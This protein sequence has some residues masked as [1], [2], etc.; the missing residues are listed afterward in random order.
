MWEAEE[1]GRLISGMRGAFAD[2]ADELEVTAECNPASFD[3]SVGEAFALAGINRISLGVQSLDNERLRFLGRLHDSEQ[4]LRAI[5]DAQ[6]TH[7]RVSCDLMFGMPGQS[8]DD[9]HEEI[10]RVV[11][12]GIRHVSAY[13]LTIEPETPFGALHREGKLQVAPEEEYADLFEGATRRFESLGFEHYEV[14]N[15]AAPGEESVHNLHYWRGGDYLGLG[16]GA[17]GCV[18]SAQGKARRWRN[19][20]DSA[21]YMNAAGSEAQELESESLDAQDLIREALMLGLRTLEGVDLKAAETRAGVDPLE[22]RAEAVERHLERGNLL[23][24]V[25]EEGARLRVPRARWL[26]LDGIVA[27]LF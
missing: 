1:L 5:D 23:L 22:G 7:E 14:S 20:P 3:R 26:H 12:R 16:A 17:V 11:A 18:T 21:R 15:Y 24:D 13:A 2:A 9:L 27:D 25:C 19:D 4:A 8:V 6:R 10:E